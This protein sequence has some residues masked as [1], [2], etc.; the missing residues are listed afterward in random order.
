ML[1]CVITAPSR[2]THSRPTQNVSHGIA[3][4]RLE[5]C[6]TRTQ[7]GCGSAPCPGSTAGPRFHRNRV[8]VL[9]LGAPCAGLRSPPPPQTNKECRSVG[10]S[11][12]FQPSAAL[13][14]QQIHN[15][16]VQWESGTVKYLPPYTP[17][18]SRT[19]D[20]YPEVSGSE[21]VYFPLPDVCD[22]HTGC[23]ELLCLKISAGEFHGW[24]ISFHPRIQ[25]V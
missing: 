7:C 15:S 18:E 3:E 23:K 12:V 20:I 19:L 2:P 17:D 24:N 22:T 13:I 25:S 6:S 16:K 10:L 14:G 4:T 1:C 9:E 8:E 5:P 21:F 11:A